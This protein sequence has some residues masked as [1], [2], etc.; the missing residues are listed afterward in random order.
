MK[1]RELDC[2]GLTQL[3]DFMELLAYAFDSRCKFRFKKCKFKFEGDVFMP[4]YQF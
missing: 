4:N 2:L 3:G 1:I